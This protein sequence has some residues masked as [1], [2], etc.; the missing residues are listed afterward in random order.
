[1]LRD[2]FA[3]SLFGFKECNTINS[4]AYPLG[5]LESVLQVPQAHRL[6]IFVA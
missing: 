5:Y 6:P 4:I 1:M 2:I 3:L